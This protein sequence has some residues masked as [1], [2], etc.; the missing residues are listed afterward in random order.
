MR[1]SP[2]EKPACDTRDGNNQQA[3][4]RRIVRQDEPGVT[5]KLQSGSGE[6]FELWK[7]NAQVSLLGS[8]MVT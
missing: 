6:G 4:I 7:K 3:A 1:R 8:E 2:L 5:A